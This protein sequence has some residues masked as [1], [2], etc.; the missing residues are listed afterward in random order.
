MARFVANPVIVEAVQYRSGDVAC[1]PDEFRRALHRH[2]GGGRVEVTTGDGPRPLLDG[3]WVVHGPDGLFS[4]WR[5]AAFEV[6]FAPRVPHVVNADDDPGDAE[7][8]PGEATAASGQ[9][10]RAQVER[11]KSASSGKSKA[12][13]PTGKSTPKI[14]PVSAPAETPP[15]SAP[16]ET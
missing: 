6:W 15:V 4:V 3:D 12:K 9:P 13:I 5:E 7:E 16:A 11:R 1:W 14:T 8:A 10:A 2:I